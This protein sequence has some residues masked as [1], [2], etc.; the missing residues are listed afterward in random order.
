[1]FRCAAA[2]L[3]TLIVDMP[4]SAD[5]LV[6]L[7]VILLTSELVAVGVANSLASFKPLNSS[8][9]AWTLNFKTANAEILA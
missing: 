9:S 1:M 8:I 6:E 7:T 5:P 4:L 3:E 2:K